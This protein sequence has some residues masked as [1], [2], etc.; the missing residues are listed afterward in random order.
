MRVAV[1]GSTGRTGALHC[2]HEETSAENLSE[3]E[4][5]RRIPPVHDNVS[6]TQAA[7]PGE[8]Q[9]VGEKRGEMYSDFDKPCRGRS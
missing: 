2:Q 5:K 6:E 4:G 9:T 3:N 7:D 8:D 1:F